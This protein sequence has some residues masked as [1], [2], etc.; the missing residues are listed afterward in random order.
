MT[1]YYDGSTASQTISLCLL[2]VTALL[3]LLLVGQDTS[4]SF[5]FP[6]LI[7]WFSS[8]STIL[9]NTHPN[10][11]NYTFALLIAGLGKSS[12]RPPIYIRIPRIG[13]RNAQLQKPLEPRRRRRGS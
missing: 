7:H 13:S 11:N 3:F 1:D 9:G 10:F 2:P 12:L 8:A 5:P 4:I 6:N